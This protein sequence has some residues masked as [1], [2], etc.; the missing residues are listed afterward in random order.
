MAYVPFAPYRLLVADRRLGLQS[1]VKHESQDSETTV[2]R[3]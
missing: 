1:A 3:T 2:V